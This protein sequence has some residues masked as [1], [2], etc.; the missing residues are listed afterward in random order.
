MQGEMA[1]SWEWNRPPEE[2][3]ARWYESRRVSDLRRAYVIGMR[4]APAEISRQTGYAVSEFLKSI[5]PALLDVCMIQAGSTA[6]GAGLGALIGSL[7]GGVGAGPGAAYG[8]SLGFSVSATILVWLG[9]TFLFIEVGKNLGEVVV[10]V[11]SAVK[12]AWHASDHP[13]SRTATV[14]QAGSTLA[15]AMGLLMLLVLQAIVAWVLKKGIGKVPELLAELRKSRLGEGFTTWVEQNLQTLMKDPKL[16][17]RQVEASAAKAP[18]ERAMS[19]SEIKRLR[20]DGLAATK[21]KKNETKPQPTIHDGQQGKHIPEHN[22][23]Q[24][25][26]SELT[27][28][29]PQR[30][31]QEGAGQGQQIG[32]TPIGQPGSKERVDFGRTIG[33]Y[34]DPVTGE[35]TPTNNGIIHYGSRGAH[36]VPSRP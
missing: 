33:N 18:E 13:W 30:L 9:L 3:D 29:N 27:D 7:A 34:V 20:E 19:P 35:K 28:S 5:L 23:F 8:A 31:L 26:K 10:L 4:D 32:D 16:Q 36:I 15:R 25:G 12:Q 2:G 17:P 14:Q 6:I 11:Q 1:M 21:A 24:P 22:N